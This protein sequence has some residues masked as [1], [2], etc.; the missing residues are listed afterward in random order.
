MYGTERY[1]TISEKAAILCYTLVT[2]HAFVDGNKRIG[3]VAMKVFLRLNDYDTSDNVDSGESMI[4]KIAS[5][6]SSL[7][8]LKSW[9]DNSITKI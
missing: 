9:I 7:A 2:R 1:L 3:Y 6:R 4:I 8:E 5:G